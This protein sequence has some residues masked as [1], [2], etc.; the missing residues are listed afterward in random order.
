[1]FTNGAAVD[2]QAHLPLT[3]LI[4]TVLVPSGYTASV[5]VKVPAPGAVVHTSHDTSFATPPGE[6][7]FS[8]EPC[9]GLDRAEAQPM[10]QPHIGQQRTK[11][12]LKTPIK[13]RLLR[14]VLA[15]GETHMTN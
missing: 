5:I 10:Q 8:P 11:R 3:V 14:T 12:N 9:P 6:S 7:H 4:M 15:K 13:T 2:N 1:M